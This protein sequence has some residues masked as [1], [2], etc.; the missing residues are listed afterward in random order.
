M[1]STPS[2]KT[3]EETEPNKDFHV[4]LLVMYSVLFVC[5]TISLSLM[6]HFIKSSSSSLTSIAILNLIF[7]HFVFLLTVPFRIYY[8]ATN[9]WHLG[10]NWCRMV[11]CMIHFHMYVSFILYVIILTSRLMTFYNKAACFASVQRMHA[12]IISAVVWI[13]LVVMGICTTLL[14]Y[15]QNTDRTNKNICFKFGKN[16]K[17]IKPINYI[18][19][20]VIIVVTFVLTALQAN[21]LRVLYKKHPQEWTSQQ[22]FRAQ[23][24]SF[25]FALIMLCSIPYH[26]FRL[27]Y[28]NNKTFEDFNEVFLSLTAFICLD[29]LT[30]LGRRTC[31]VYNLYGFLCTSI[32]I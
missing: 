11:S 24:K 1:T 6:M 25:I 10:E 29:M 13:V 12:L 20:I 30:F 8:F 21:V 17:E 28:L 7:A 16:I 5:G 27:Y 4:V 18:I 15:G 22:E 32:Y 9:N 3:A 23:L 14:L 31:N 19:S 2:N 26:A